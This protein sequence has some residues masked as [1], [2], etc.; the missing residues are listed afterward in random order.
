MRSLLLFI[1]VALVAGAAKGKTAKV[2]PPRT[3]PPTVS[4]TAFTTVAP[5]VAGQ[6][7]QTAAPGMMLLDLKAV[8]TNVLQLMEAQKFNEAAKLFAPG[9]AY[10]TNGRTYELDLSVP[11]DIKSIPKRNRT[12]CVWTYTDRD[13]YE[14][15]GSLF[16][17]VPKP[18]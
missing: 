6:T 12:Q 1:M 8:A 3:E 18:D 15:L 16:G 11:G 17:H 14:N 4:P 7:A 10:I 9:M 5:S 2:S 13:E